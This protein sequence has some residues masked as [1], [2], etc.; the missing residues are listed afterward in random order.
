MNETAQRFS[1]N[2]PMMRTDT[3]PDGPF[4]RY[5]DLERA[6]NSHD[7]MLAALSRQADNMAFIINHV[8]LPEQ[9]RDKFM[10]ELDEDRAA[11]SKAT[12][13]TA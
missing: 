3:D 13:P 8:T 5:A 9:W 11:I 6:V 4:V 12:T 7:D 1:I 10:R 2:F